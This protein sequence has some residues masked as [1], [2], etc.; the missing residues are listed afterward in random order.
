MSRWAGRLP[1]AAAALI[2]VGALGWLALDPRIPRKAFEDYSL[3]N[4]SPKGLSL[5]SRYL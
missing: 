4:T 5:A 2:T 1:W 3:Y